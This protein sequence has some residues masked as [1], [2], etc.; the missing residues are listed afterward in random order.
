MLAQKCIFRHNS[1]GVQLRFIS[2]LIFAYR[3]QAATVTFE[4]APFVGGV[5]RRYYIFCIYARVLEFFV[6]QGAAYVELNHQKLLILVKKVRF[7]AE[8]HL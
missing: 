3:L 2:S 6:A 8:L 5:G 1:V 4:G 7:Y